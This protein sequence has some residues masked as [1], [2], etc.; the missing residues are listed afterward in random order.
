MIEELF[1][2]IPWNKKMEVLRVG[3]GW[4]QRLAG[5]KCLTHSKNYWLWEKGKCYP[6]LENRKLIAGA[7]GLKVEHIFSE[8]DRK[9]RVF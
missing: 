2:K 9:I 5:E 4:G 7:F 8:D 6:R 1:N 3:N